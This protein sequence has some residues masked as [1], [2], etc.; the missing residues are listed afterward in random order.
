MCVAELGPGH[1]NHQLLWLGIYYLFLC[2]DL[3]TIAASSRVWKRLIFAARVRTAAL[4]YQVSEAPYIW[5]SV[6][7]YQS[8]CLYLVGSSYQRGFRNLT[9]GLC[10]IK[11]GCHGFERHQK[12]G[13]QV[14]LGNGLCTIP[15]VCDG[16]TKFLKHV[17]I[18]YILTEAEL[19]KIKV[20]L[21]SWSKVH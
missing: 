3:N 14:F 10:C 17:K 16:R 7:L 21:H 8:S 1:W 11:F 12:S 5:L 4:E 9:S 13:R 2:G 20:N 18:L 15:S 19:E 6:R